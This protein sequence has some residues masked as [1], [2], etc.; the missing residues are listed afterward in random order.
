MNDERVK[1]RIEEM[2][3]W[4]W[5]NRKAVIQLEQAYGRAVRSKDD[6]AV[7]YILDK[8]AVGLIK[9]NREMFHDWFLEAIVEDI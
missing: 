3:D 8:S 9:R 1:Y 6:E 5:Y 7:F 2:N 4:D